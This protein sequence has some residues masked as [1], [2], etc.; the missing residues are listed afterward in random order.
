LLGVSVFGVAL[1]KLGLIPERISALGIEFRR[2]DQQ[3]LLCITALVTL[4]FL[5]AFVVYASTDFLSWRLSLVE[6]LAQRYINANLG[7]RIRSVRTPEPVLK[8]DEKEM[9]RLKFYGR[10][11][12]RFLFALFGPVSVARALIEF[13]LPI[14]FGAYAVVLLLSTRISARP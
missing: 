4:Y 14:I 9:L 1:V 8:P 11:I 2:V 5:T 10:G 3:S 7:D 12:V 13:L 6:T